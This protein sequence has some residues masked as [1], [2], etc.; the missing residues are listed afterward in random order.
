LL[1]HL[2]QITPTQP[3]SSF[4]ATSLSL[5]LV[6]ALYNRLSSSLVSSSL[7]LVLVAPHSQSGS[8]LFFALDRVTSH[9]ISLDYD[10]AIQ[11]TN[12]CS[13]SLVLPPHTDFRHRT[14]VEPNR[15]FIHCRPIRCQDRD[16]IVFCR[17]AFVALLWN[18]A[19]DVEVQV[20]Q[21]GLSHLLT[22]ASNCAFL[23]L[24]SISKAVQAA[25]PA[26][27][28]SKAP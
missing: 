27:A 13:S 7:V 28:L 9:I 19:V 3:Q 26:L 16:Q 12:R 4:A 2:V 17:L 24:Q 15:R 14:A 6:L 10:L 25:L 11:T 5:S 1:S 8:V 23:S 18:C 20:V 21:D 22:G